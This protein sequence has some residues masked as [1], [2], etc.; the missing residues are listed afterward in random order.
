MAEFFM[1]AKPKVMVNKM[2]STKAI[3]NDDQCPNQSC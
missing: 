1:S 3:D 2:A